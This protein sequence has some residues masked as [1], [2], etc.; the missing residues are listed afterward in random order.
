MKQFAKSLKNLLEIFF[1]WLSLLVI[2][3]MLLITTGQIFLRNFFGI[4]LNI[5]SEIAR[6]GLI[7]LTFTGGILATLHSKHIAID[8]ASRLLHGKIRKALGTLLNLSAAA[9]SFFMAYYAFNFVKMEYEFAGTIADVIPVWT[10]QVIIPIGFFFIALSF[11][12]NIFS[13]EELQA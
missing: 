11:L 4:N 7:W 6:Q 8:L 13:E 1:S 3:G 2:A 9:I 12:L 10:I 5:A